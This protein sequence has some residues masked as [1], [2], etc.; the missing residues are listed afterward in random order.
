[1]DAILGTWKADKSTFENAKAFL[2]AA[3]VPEE[4]RKDLSERE[5]EITYSKEGE[6]LKCVVKVTNSPVAKEKTYTIDIGQEKDI[7]SVEGIKMKAKV[8]WDGSK[9][10]ENYTT[11]EGAEFATTREI[12]GDTMKVTSTTKGVTMSQ[13]WRKS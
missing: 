13:I 3:S 8:D 4:H 12:T 9:F 2:D 1:M 7:E 6:Q 11:A 10:V 5:M